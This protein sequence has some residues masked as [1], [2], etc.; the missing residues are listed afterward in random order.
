VRAA[1][2]GSQAGIV[3]LG[4]IGMAIATRLQALGMRIGYFGRRRKEGV[5]YPFFADLEGLAAW[6]D[7][8]LVATPGGPETEGLISARVL[9]A[10]G[11]EGT[12]VNVSRGSVVDET[13][14]IGALQRGEIASAGLDVYRN[15]PD[16]DPAFAALGNVVLYPHHASG[17]VETRDRMAEMTLGNLAAFFAGEPLLTP[18]N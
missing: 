17:T 2:A 5:D 10:L 11:P 16:P 18:V 12:F 7:I 14:L 3:G 8:L 1:T 9:A 4:K 15:E 13:A 6:S